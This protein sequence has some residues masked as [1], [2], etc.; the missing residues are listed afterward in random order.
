MV[1][2]SDLK[3]ERMIASDFWNAAARS[4]VWESV[5]LISDGK[6]FIQFNDSEGGARATSLFQVTFE[7]QRAVPRRKPSQTAT[8]QR[9]RDSTMLAPAGSHSEFRIRLRVC[10]LKAEKVV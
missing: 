5:A 10:R 1:P 8:M 7:P 4:A 9:T 2:V 3:C 6:S